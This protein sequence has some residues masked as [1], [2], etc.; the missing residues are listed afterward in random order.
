MV[1]LDTGFFVAMMKGDKRTLLLWDNLQQQGRTSIVSVLT[2]CELLYIY[3]KIGK[4]ETGRTLI[5]NI[6][7]ASIVKFV[8]E[9]IVTRAAG[10][11]HG[12]SIPF[13]DALIMATFLES[14]C[15][16]M[17]TSDRKHFGTIGKMKIDLVFY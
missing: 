17:H 12:L 8:D 13:I 3:Y 9:N 16:E 1:G 6:K 4:A 2:L 5:E 15:K 14:G 7:I 10:L 11:K